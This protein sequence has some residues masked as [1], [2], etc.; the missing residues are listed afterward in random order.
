MNQN[1][2]ATAIYSAFIYCISATLVFAQ[3]AALLPNAQQVY[4]DVNG[5]PLSTGTVGFYYPSTL[6]LKPIWQDATEAT[7]YTNPVTLNSA[8][9]PPGSQGIY[10]QGAYRQIVKDVNGVTIWDA[11][12]SSAGSSSGVAATGD[13]DLVGT[14]KPW[15]GITAPNQYQ[16]AYGQQLNRTTFAALFTAITQSLAV[17]CTSTSNT[18]SGIADTTSINVGAPLE[19]AACVVPGT[20]V[21]SK[22]SS[23]VVMSN[24]SSVNLNTTAVFF[25]FGNGD[26]STTFTLPDFRG[27]TIAGRQNMGGTASTNLTN[28]NAGQGTTCGNQN[29]TLA[30][31]N[32]PNVTYSPVFS[33]TLNPAATVNVNQSVL[34]QTGGGTVNSGIN[35]T[36]NSITATVTVPAFTPAGTINTFAL[37][38]GVTQTAFSTIQPTITLNYIIKITPDTNSAI[39]TGVTDI[40]GMVGSISCGA[41]IVC[42]GNTITTSGAT[43]FLNSNNTF[44]TSRQIYNYTPVFDLATN[45]LGVNE[46]FTATNVTV[47]INTNYSDIRFSQTTGSNNTYTVGSGGIVSSIYSSPEALVGS[48]ASSNVYGGVLHATNDGPGNVRGAHLGGFAIAG[49]TGTLSA[50]ALQIQP[51]STSAGA[52]GGFASLTSS[53]ANDIAIAYGIESTGDRYQYGVASTINPTAY[54]IAAYQAWMA[55]GSS[56]SARAFQIRNNAGTEIAYWHKDGTLSIGGNTISDTV[57]LSIVNGA[58]SGSV[59]TVSA[60]STLHIA[61]ADG[62][63]NQLVFDSFGGANIF[64]NR[65]ANGGAAARTGLIANDVI[66]QFNANGWNSAAAYNTASS[67]LQFIATETFSGTANGSAFKVK[68]TKNGTIVLADS[69]IVDG[70][71]HMQIGSIA[72]TSVSTCGTGAIVANSTDASGQINATGA[73]AC[74]INFGNAYASAPNCILTDNTSAVALKG[75]PATGSLVVTGLTSGDT[76][77]YVCLAKVGG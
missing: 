29:T 10:G 49:S 28:C 38:G 59:S 65:R 22:T 33:G 23:T 41:G 51:V 12:T 46:L 36:I 3:S 5:N 50:A 4:L 56:A 27:N 19:A 30:R 18:L 11:L 75:V 55:T 68:T 45:L 64:L 62:G 7:P 40:Q 73:T 6:N 77:T 1:K 15:A 67:Q 66:L 44:T 32:L 53:G 61:A 60:P 58:N 14:I 74:T 24:P 54:N 42:T 9:R 20:T 17:T 63:S 72:P 16:F 37:N 21:S 26:G 43:V 2:I 8:G 31:A 25:P 52:W 39:A 47:P 76:F 57:A 70:L 34:A 48:N 71:G 69:M 35:T 13:G